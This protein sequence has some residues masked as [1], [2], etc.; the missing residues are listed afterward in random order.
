[1]GFILRGDSMEEVEAHMN[2]I[3]PRMER[4]FLLTLEPPGKRLF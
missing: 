1:M 3:V 4:D 2:A